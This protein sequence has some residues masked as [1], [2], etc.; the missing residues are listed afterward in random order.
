MCNPSSPFNESVYGS[1]LI[2]VVA[3]VNI[4]VEWRRDDSYPDCV[5]LIRPMNDYSTPTM[6]RE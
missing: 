4:T 1:V 5:Q 2:T 6:K 3:R